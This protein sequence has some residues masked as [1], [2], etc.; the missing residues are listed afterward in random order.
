MLCS[1]VEL[2]GEE[3]TQAEAAAQVLCD[4][5]L[6]MVGNKK[7]HKQICN[8]LEVHV[9][10][11]LSFLSSGQPDPCRKPRQSRPRSLAEFGTED[12]SSQGNGSGFLTAVCLVQ[13]FLG[14]TETHEFVDWLWETLQQIE[15]KTFSLGILSKSLSLLELAHEPPAR[16][17]RRVHSARLCSHPRAAPPSEPLCPHALF[18]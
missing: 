8:D 12:S 1:L 13:T 14:E 6:V 9:P 2:L 10:G 4:Y 17:S 5:V 16:L 15:D 11:P 3:G 18:R 7:T